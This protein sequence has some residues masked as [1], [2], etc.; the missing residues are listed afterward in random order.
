LRLL[1]E[2]SK[3]DRE[4]RNEKPN[5]PVTNQPAQNASSEPFAIIASRPNYWLP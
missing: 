3:Q 4:T 1:R 5:R 2:A